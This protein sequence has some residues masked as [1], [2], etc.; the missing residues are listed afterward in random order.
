MVIQIRNSLHRH[1]GEHY[2]FII[3]FY[4]LDELSLEESPQLLEE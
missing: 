3:F 2:L 1:S 4:I